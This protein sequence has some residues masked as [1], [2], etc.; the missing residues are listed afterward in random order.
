MLKKP[1]LRTFV[2][3][4]WSDWLA[5]MSGSMSVPFATFGTFF[6]S[7]NAKSLWW[8]LAMVCVA[9][10][11]YRLWKKE[12]QALIEAK[13]EAGCYIPESFWEKL[14]PPT[15]M[16]L[17]DAA[18]AVLDEFKDT[19]FEQIGSMF[20]DLNGKPTPEM[21]CASY[22]L[23]I[24]YCS[25]PIY[26]TEP[27]SKILRKIHNARLLAMR[28]LIGSESRYRCLCIKRRDLKRVF[29]EIKLELPNISRR[30]QG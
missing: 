12:R 3:V 5:L 30:Y 10:A 26:G 11:G 13:G 19:P 8:L 4:L 25:V 23:Q 24:A 9:T 6:A 2:A 28:S 22:A 14:C 1:T 21:I 20:A 7:S 27:P 15:L 16:P 29:A 17:E 18:I